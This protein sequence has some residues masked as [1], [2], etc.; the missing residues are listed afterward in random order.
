[1][2]G[3]REMDFVMQIPPAVHGMMDV[4]H[5]NG[6]DAYLV[7]GCVRDALMGLT[8]HDYDITTNARPEQII[9]LFGEEDCTWYGKAFGTVC[10]HRDG[11]QAEVTTYRT[12]GD[13]TDSRHPGRVDF[14]DDVHDDLSR[15]DFT[16]NAIAY[17]PRTGL[18]DPYHGADDLQNS[19]LRAVGTAD[20]RFSEDALRILRGL[21]FYARFGLVPEAA[22][23]AAMR[24]HAPELANIS[25]ERVFTELCGM[26]KGEHITTV[27]LTYPDVLAVWI[28]EI[29]PC[30]GFEQ[31]SKWHDFTVWEHIARTVG[32]VVPDLP[33]RLA[34]LFHDI[35]KPDCFT[36]DA[37]GGHF[38]GHAHRSA[39]KADHALKRLRCDNRTREQAVQLIELHRG[40]PKRMST[41]RRLLGELG[42]EQFWRLI[43]VMESDRVS[44]WRDRAGSRER[45]DRME[46]CLNGHMTQG[47]CCGIAD[48]EIDG[49]DLIALGYQGREIGEM[50]HMVLEEVIHDR[51]RNEREALLEYV[52][53]V[54]GTS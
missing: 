11:G 30:V 49:R 29:T 42:E 32:N 53:H 50:L 38:M 51:L 6:F 14:A 39:V 41:C 1:M 16:C 21:R 44:K 28:P 40:V 31:H 17:D 13:Y 2:K 12:E 18:L 19:I 27:L 7:G 33:L 5:E 20:Q 3:V 37:R 34:M 36:L 43:Q 23:D 15:R 26:L 25:V 22:T 54:P 24:A 45:I 47:L 48:L 9:A 35:A 52:R 46:E 4:L 8:P 10:V